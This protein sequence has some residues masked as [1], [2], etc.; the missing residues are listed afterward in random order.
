MNSFNE[1]Q[2]GLR[3]VKGWLLTHEHQFDNKE[4]MSMSKPCHGIETPQRSPRGATVRS[5][6]TATLGLQ[7]VLECFLVS[8]VTFFYLLL[9]RPSTTQSTS[10]SL[11]LPPS[12]T[13]KRSPL[14]PTTY[15]TPTPPIYRPITRPQALTTAQPHWLINAV[16]YLGLNPPWDRLPW[17][18]KQ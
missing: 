14:S 18:H 17:R 7:R 3:S 4:L 16:L 11:S 13:L 1:A 2:F 8:P 9:N 15:L 5:L 10:Y 6:F 12:H